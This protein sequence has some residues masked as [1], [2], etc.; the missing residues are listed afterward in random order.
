MWGKTC[1]KQR[2][3][4]ALLGSDLGI[5]HQANGLIKHRLGKK[6]KQK[7]L[8]GKSNMLMYAKKK[9]DTG[10]TLQTMG[11]KHSFYFVFYDVERFI[12]DTIFI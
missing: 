6:S 2:T 3:S 4:L 11:N 5:E 12:Y 10:D 7:Q 9:G 1:L 8:E